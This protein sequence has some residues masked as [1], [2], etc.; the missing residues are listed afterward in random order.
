MP[1]DPLAP[2]AE[3]EKAAG[4]RR[5]LFWVVDD[6]P[7][8]IAGVARRLPRAAAIA[9]VYTPPAHRGRGFAGSVSAALAERLFA[10]GKS[11]VCLYVDM[12]NAAS[13][14]C[15]AKIGFEP[16]CDAW[17]YFRR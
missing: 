14:R 4:D 12:R 2:R 1:D 17:V 11:A 13:N 8:S 3:L 9:P 7:V 6:N 5:H 15:Y 16:A 10:E